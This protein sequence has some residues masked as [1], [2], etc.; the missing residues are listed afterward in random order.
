MHDR[1]WTIIMLLCI[2]LGV[3]KFNSGHKERYPPSQMDDYIILWRTWLHTKQLYK[4]LY[5]T[6]DLSSLVKGLTTRLIHTVDDG[7]W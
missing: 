1:H 3:I 7:N 2:R 5:V 6:S 4:S